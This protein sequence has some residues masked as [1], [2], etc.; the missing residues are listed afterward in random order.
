MKRFAM[1][2]VYDRTGKEVGRYSFKARGKAEGH[3]RAIGGYCRMLKVERVNF[4]SYS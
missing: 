3:A 2:A 1:W 4:L